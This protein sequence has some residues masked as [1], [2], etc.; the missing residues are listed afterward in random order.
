MC[1]AITAQEAQAPNTPSTQCQEAL[2]NGGE[3][4]TSPARARKMHMVQSANLGT[5]PRRIEAFTD[6]YAAISLTSVYRIRRMA[7]MT[8]T[9]G[10]QNSGSPA[11][12][13]C[14]DWATMPRAAG[15][16]VHHV[17]RSRH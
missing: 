6:A 14:S 7:W 2:G 15:A 17:A 5:S 13:A 4:G 11:R 12:S 3:V 1:P 16:S 8:S 10:S 9:R